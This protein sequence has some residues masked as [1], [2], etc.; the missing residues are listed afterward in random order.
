VASERGIGAFL[1]FVSFIGFVEYSSFTFF[2]LFSCYLVSSLEND[3]IEG[4][5][6]VIQEDRKYVK[7]VRKVGRST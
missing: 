6:P 3:A 2:Y 5:S 4:E 1:H 7:K